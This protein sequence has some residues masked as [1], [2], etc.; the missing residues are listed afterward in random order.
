MLQK[1]LDA[2]G[3]N[4]LKH[5]ITGDIAIYDEYYDTWSISD[6]DW[7]WYSFSYEHLI[8]FGFKYD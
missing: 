8:A 2:T 6:W 3:M 7:G 5:P 1:R 4:I